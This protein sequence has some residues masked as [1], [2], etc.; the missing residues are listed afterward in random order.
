[1]VTFTISSSTSPRSLMT[2]IVSAIVSMVT[3][4]ITILTSGFLSSRHSTMDLRFPE[5][6]PMNAWVGAGRSAMASGASPLTTSRFA[7][8]NLRLF[9]SMRSAAMSS[10]SMAY[11]FPRY[12]VRA[13]SIDTEPVPAP[14]S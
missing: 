13:I 8:W 4:L 3:E 5:E 11:T 14:M 6:P 12:A 7:A 1:M 2:C 9:I 10:L